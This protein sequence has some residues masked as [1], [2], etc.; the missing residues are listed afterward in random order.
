VAADG[1][2]KDDEAGVGD[3]GSGGQSGSEDVGA[4]IEFSAEVGGVAGTLENVA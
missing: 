1:G 4:F 3:S 2:E